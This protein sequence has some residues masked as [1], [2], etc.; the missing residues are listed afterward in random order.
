MDFDRLLR[1]D[2]RAHYSRPQWG[3]NWPDG[4]PA[5]PLC[6]INNKYSMEWGGPPVNY[7]GVAELVEIME[8][9][10]ERYH[11]V[12]VRPTGRERSYGR[13]NQPIYDYAD[14]GPMQAAGATLIQDL[15]Q[16]NPNHTFNDL[17]F[18]L[19]ARSEFFVSAAGS[20]AKICSLFGG[21]NVVLL[22]R[23]WNKPGMLGWWGQIS[24]C[25]ISCA[26]SSSFVKLVKDKLNA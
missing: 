14:M 23:S 5:K 3:I 19:G 20:N 25:E 22:N 10:R 8:V 7:I 11:V 15:L 17:Q 2:Y 6:M 13:D 9:L 12:Y 26:P 21:T 4:A 24:G 1:P 18:A 16:A